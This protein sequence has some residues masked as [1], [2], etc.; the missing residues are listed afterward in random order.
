MFGVFSTEGSDPCWEWRRGADPSENIIEE[1]TFDL[2]SSPLDCD[3]AEPGC[4]KYVERFSLSESEQEERLPDPRQALSLGHLHEFLIQLSLSS[5]DSS[6]ESFWPKE[7]GDVGGLE[8]GGQ[9]VEP[10][11]PERSDHTAASERYRLTRS[12]S[13]SINSPSSMDPRVEEGCSR[14]DSAQFD[15]LILRVGGKILSEFLA[16][17]GV[18]RSI[19]PT[20]RQ[21]KCIYLSLFRGEIRWKMAHIFYRIWSERW[22]DVR[23]KK[24]VDMNGLQANY[25]TWAQFFFRIVGQKNQ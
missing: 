13:S 15:A 11:L 23:K 2:S 6:I 14:E 7:R 16:K 20:A 21:L 22:Q 1:S 4:R 9:R 24:A 3:S 12:D 5:P 25:R 17:A 10:S 8:E 19:S 18:N